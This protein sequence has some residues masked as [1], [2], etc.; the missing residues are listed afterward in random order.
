MDLRVK[1]RDNFAEVPI[2]RYSPTREIL[3]QNN[4]QKEFLHE[5]TKSSSFKRGIKSNEKKQFHF[6][7][8]KNKENFKESLDYALK[9]FNLRTGGVD[10]KEI[11]Q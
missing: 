7:R 4:D 9:S 6:P 10:W 1:K 2:R 3:Q 8:I 11:P 5:L